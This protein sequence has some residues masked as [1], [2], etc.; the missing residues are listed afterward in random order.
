MRSLP[1]FARARSAA[2]RSAGPSASAARAAADKPAPSS[3]SP[4]RRRAVRPE[5]FARFTV[6]KSSSSSAPSTGCRNGRRRALDHAPVA[7]SPPAPHSSSDDVRSARVVR[8]TP[9]RLSRR[10][11]RRRL[12]RC[13]RRPRRVVALRRR[14]RSR[15][16]DFRN[17]SL[18]GFGSPTELANASTSSASTSNTSLFGWRYTL[19]RYDTTALCARYFKLRV[20]PEQT[21]D[22]DDV[23][24]HGS[25]PGSAAWSSAAPWRPRAPSANAASDGVRS[26]RPFPLRRCIAPCARLGG[27]STARPRGSPPGRPS[28]RRGSRDRARR[29]RWRRARRVWRRKRT[30][31]SPSAPF[32]SSARGA[33]RSARPVA[34][35]GTSRAR[36][37]PACSWTKISTSCTRG[38]DL[39]NA[40]SVSRVVPY[41][42]TSG[43]SSK[44]SDG[45]ERHRGRGLNARDP[46]RRDAPGKV[47]KDRRSPRR[48]GRMG[49][50]VRQN[51]PPS[52]SRARTS[53]RA[54]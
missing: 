28:R 24:G 48:R 1:F 11:V 49:T 35:A 52:S 41:E 8:G 5:W 15:L 27:C 9:P 18:G 10:R 47:L 31:T 46:G 45:V 2:P 19:L 6:I 54:A 14:P 39:M 20:L 16:C 50:S 3:S 25:S 42:R 7:V 40:H 43:W 4:R 33:S 21:L 17:R 53:R 32:A 22:A 44:A 38:G 23:I 12:R 13:R 51:A 29:R 34:S 30:E 36:T 26:S 37:E